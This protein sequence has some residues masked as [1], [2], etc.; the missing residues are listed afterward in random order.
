[1]PNNQ[2][3]DRGRRFE[4]IATT[5]R[6]RDAGRCM[7]CSKP[8]REAQ[9]SVHHLLPDS[10]VPEQV[11][12]HLPVNLVTLCRECHPK[13]ESQTVAY[14]LNELEIDDTMNLMLGDETRQR[15][16]DRLDETGPDILNIKNIHQEESE[17]F[18]EEHYNSPGGQSDL[19]EFSE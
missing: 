6:N 7:R 17:K 2:G 15:L 10:Q 3:Q 8:E 14:Q 16:N 9:L 11:D 18:I 19:T 4:E 12:A 13:M 5:V 1:M